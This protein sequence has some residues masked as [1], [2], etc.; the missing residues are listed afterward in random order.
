MLFLHLTLFLPHTGHH[1]A[2]TKLVVLRG[3]LDVNELLDSGGVGVEDAVAV[4]AWLF[5][6]VDVVGLAFAFARH[7]ELAVGVGH[8][9]V[10]V[11]VA[12]ALDLV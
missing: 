11:K 12:P 6:G 2:H 3:E 1:S 7:E 4:L 10:D 8:G 5:H 9:V